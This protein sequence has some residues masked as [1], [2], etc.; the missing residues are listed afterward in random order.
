MNPITIL[1]R[2]CV[3][4]LLLASAV[5]AQAAHIRAAL[6]AETSRPA[7]GSR[8]TIALSMTPQPD[9]HGYWLNPGD[10]GLPMKVDWSLPPGYSVG[11]LRYPVPTRLT[12]AG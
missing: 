3:A 11:Q 5:G 6:V 1:A 10:A 7:P 8:V 9:W 2:L 12:V 4:V